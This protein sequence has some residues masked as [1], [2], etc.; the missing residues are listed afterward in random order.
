MSQERRSRPAGENGTAS[1]TAADAPKY[2]VDQAKVVVRRLCTRRPAVG[3][4][5]VQLE[6]R[7]TS[8]HRS[9]PLD[10]GCRD[11]W[12]RC[13]EPPLSD[14]AI[15]G[16]RAAALHVLA[17]GRAPVVPIEVLRALYRRGGDDRTLAERLYALSGGEVA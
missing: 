3:G 2:S 12:C 10:C 6:R 13:T 4:I 7:R 11:P 5:P 16:W 15:D 17:C 14:H 9:E 8:A 1:T